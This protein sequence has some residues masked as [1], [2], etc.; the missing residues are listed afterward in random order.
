MTLLFDVLKEITEMNT[1]ELVKN[2]KK[3]IL[4]KPDEECSY[5]INIDGGIFFDLEIASTKEL[6]VIGN[7]GIHYN[8]T[9]IHNKK[10]ELKTEEEF[11]QYSLLNDVGDLD[12]INYVR[13]VTFQQRMISELPLIKGKL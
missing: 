6:I 4:A 13:M 1:P 3:Y 7:I 8:N 5:Y 9:H 12:Y 11:F 2:A 10:Y